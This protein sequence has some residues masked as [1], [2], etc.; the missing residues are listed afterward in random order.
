MIF[1]NDDSYL[2]E[3]PLGPAASKTAWIIFGVF[4]ALL[5]AAYFNMLQYA[6]TYWNKGLYSHGWIVPLIAGYLFSLRRKP[7]VDASNQ[8][9]WI[10]VGLLVACLALRVWAAN[11]DYNNPERASFLGALLACCLIVGGRSMLIWAGPALAFLAF[12]FPLPNMLE[13]TMLIKLQN[14]AT[15]ISTWTLQLLGIGAARSGNVIS[16]DNIN[17]LTVAE[18]CSGLRMLTIFCAMAVALVMI[19]DRPWWDKL[20]ILVMAVPIAIISNVIRIVTTG[21]LLLAFGEDTPW[22]NTLIHD[23][24]GFAMMPIGLGL[25]WILLTILSHLTIP[26]DSADFG[27]FGAPAA[28]ARPAP[29]R[30]GRM[31]PA[32]R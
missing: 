17:D 28:P 16:I 2:E 31:A 18:A 7:L 29:P 20:F 25:L 11:F 32:G 26:V 19:I 4:M 23:W 12:M 27:H 1:A 5:G 21:L 13:N 22:L 30:E 24:A 10:G 9:R 8:D 15:I 14:V 6:S 3:R